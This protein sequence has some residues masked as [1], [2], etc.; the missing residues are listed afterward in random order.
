MD[1]GD[2][3]ALTAVVEVGR[4]LGLDRLVQLLVVL[5]HDGAFGDV[6]EG[7]AACIQLSHTIKRLTSTTMLYCP[8][9]I[10]MNSCSL[11]TNQ[12]FVLHLVSGV[13]T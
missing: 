5:L 1:D 3:L 13:E 11:R 12:Q 9:T 2:H 6:E 4:H 8:C 7:A 10:F